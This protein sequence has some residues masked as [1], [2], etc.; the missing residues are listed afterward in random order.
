MTTTTINDDDDDDEGRISSSLRWTGEDGYP[1]HDGRDYTN[2]RSFVSRS[3]SLLGNGDGWHCHFLGV[4]RR[5]GW[6]R[7][8]CGSSSGGK[9]T[10]AS[11]PAVGENHS[12][13]TELKNGFVSTAPQ[14]EDAGMTRRRLRGNANTTSQPRR[15]PQTCPTRRNLLRAW[16][17]ETE[18]MIFYLPDARLIRPSGR[19]P[20]HHGKFFLF[21]CSNNCFI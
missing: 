17:E 15:V 10:A 5:M 18:S 4:C 21:R 9:L 20:L 2:G 19:N 3:P 8:R 7:T 11:C 6:V 14:N 13:R 16:C 12:R 1:R